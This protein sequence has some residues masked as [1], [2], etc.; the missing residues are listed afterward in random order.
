MFSSSAFYLLDT[1]FSIISAIF[2]DV[3]VVV[4]SAMAVYFST[5]SSKKILSSHI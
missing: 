2:L 1:L 4:V 5:K 3:A